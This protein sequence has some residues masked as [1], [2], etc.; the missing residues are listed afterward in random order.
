MKKKSRRSRSSETLQQTSGKQMT[1]SVNEEKRTSGNRGRPR[2]IVPVTT[3]NFYDDN[4][5]TDKTADLDFNVTAA[6][7]TGKHP[8]S[9]SKSSGEWLS[10]NPNVLCLLL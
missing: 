6:D 2:K 10:T 8:E 9:K 7:D 5:A 1:V 3:D 4:T